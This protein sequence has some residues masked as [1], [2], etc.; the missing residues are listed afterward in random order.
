[1]D[2]IS[3]ES[4]K[5]SWSGL[6][7]IREFFRG[8]TPSIG[9]R[10]WALSAG[11]WFLAI[12][13]VRWLA[14]L[15]VENTF[16]IT[17][18]WWQLAVGFYLAEVLVVHLQFRKDAHT[19]SMSE[20][21]MVL[22]LL[23]ASPLALLVG[24]LVGSAAALVIHRRQSPV[25]L[26]VN[27]GHLA[28]QTVVAVAVFTAIAPSDGVDFMTV[29]GAVAAM[30]A[31][32]TVGHAAVLAAIRASGG[33]ESA[34]ET[35]RVF[36]VSSLGT[37][38]AATLAIVAAVVATAT[39]DVWWLGFAPVLF[40]YIAYRGYVSQSRDK[41]RIEALF[42]A[43]TELHRTPQIDRAV[44]AVAERLND[45]VRSE[46][47]AVV[48]YSS[49]DDLVPYLT[50]VDANGVQHVMS[51]FPDIALALR[52][53]IQH[54]RADVLGPAEL[55][56]LAGVLGPDIDVRNAVAGKLTVGGETVG[57]LAGVNRVGDLSAFD[58]TDA[59]VLATLG[60]QLSTSLENG[61]L[62]ESL[63]EIRTLKDQLEGLVASKDRLIASVSHEL[64][65]PLTGV[66][67]LTSLV[68][69][70]SADLLDPESTSLLD[71][72][73]EQGTE[74]SN[75]IEDLLTHARAEAGTL[76]IDPVE[77]DVTNEVMTVA[78]SHNISAPEPSVDVM[79]IGDPLRARQILRNLIT[80][81][82]RYGGSDVS[83]HVEATPEI[84]YVSVVDDG[85][86]IPPDQV[87]GIFEPYRSAQTKVAPGS[88]G[89]GLAV[90]RSMAR[91]MNGDV[92]YDLFDG[93]TRFTLSL[94][95]AAQRALTPTPVEIG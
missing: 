45:L 67:G 91:M 93:K 26:A 69:E 78:A 46:V 51:P 16:D 81:A 89:L 4:R 37:L 28:L 62:S 84:V 63:S 8:A 54:S 31:A 59:R 42:E 65:T 43:A 71:L 44:V 83:L 17:L 11:L 77:F 80:N 25:K 41:E 38:G 60:S 48:V 53:F 34:R 18:T 90:S 9:W 14:G 7:G 36:A 6:K 68:R 66:I 13:G 20:L 52:S 32:L 82:I 61:R 95:A 94:P 75:I 76:H 12:V 58:D 47:A 92:T 57:V 56:L 19:L 40:V 50:V 2:F 24:Q 55:S 27:L 39:P 86:G 3:A 49:S 23:F 22:G 70:T 88:V 10:I 33:H 85:S 74:L 35:G 79:A 73:V 5:S 15:P 64:R 29:V 21:P 30:M 72:V 1:M 87:E